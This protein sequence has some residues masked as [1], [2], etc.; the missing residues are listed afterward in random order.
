MARIP[1]ARSCLGRTW[2]ARHTP[3]RTAL[4][5]TS[6]VWIT[7]PCSSYKIVKPAGVQSNK[8]GPEA[9]LGQKTHRKDYL[10]KT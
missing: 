4:K 8:C 3:D 10:H 6:P 2:N 5:P 9:A 7:A 1:E